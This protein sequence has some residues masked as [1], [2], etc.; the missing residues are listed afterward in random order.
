M[1]YDFTAK[2]Q[3]DHC[4]DEIVCP[5]QVHY[6]ESEFHENKET[7]GDYQQWEIL[8]RPLEDIA[9]N[10]FNWGTDAAKG[11]DDQSSEHPNNQG[12]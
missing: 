8:S 5:N 1:L 4:S 12:D 10:S 6:Y 2:C 9:I 11:E 7:A 3:L